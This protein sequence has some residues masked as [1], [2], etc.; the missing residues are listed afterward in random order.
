MLGEGERERE[1][2]G[3]VLGE[4]KERETGRDSL[5]AVLGTTPFWGLPMRTSQRTP[6]TWTPQEVQR[7][8]LDEET[9]SAL[10]ADASSL[11]L[12]W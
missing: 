9:T 6:Q 8:S 7:C 3:R 10:S 2:G 5:R 1:R 11:Q 4:E 12:S